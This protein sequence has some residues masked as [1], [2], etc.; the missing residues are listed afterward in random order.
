[1]LS[2]LWQLKPEVTSEIATIFGEGLERT[3]IDPA[4][5]VAGTHV[6]RLS[7]IPVGYAPDGAAVTAAD[8]VGEPGPGIDTRVGPFAYSNVAAPAADADVRAYLQRAQKSL[9]QDMPVVMTL[10]QDDTQLDATGTY[11]RPPSG[12]LSPSAY[13][14]LVTVFDLSVH[15]SEF[16]LLAAGVPETRPEALA[17]SLRPDSTPTVLRARNPFWGSYDPGATLPFA[18]SV[19]TNDY[20]LEYLMMPLANQGRRVVWGLTLPNDPD[21]VISKVPPAPAKL[22]A[23]P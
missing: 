19:G 2:R 20:T 18:G 14:H 8:L 11:Q 1:V 21:V 16:G 17:A 15:T 12:A 9:N 6:H 22:P 7:E 10:M 13:S 3:L 4:V 23:P 5:D